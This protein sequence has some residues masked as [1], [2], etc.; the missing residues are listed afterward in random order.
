MEVARML[1]VRKLALGLLLAMAL[2]CATVSAQPQVAQ[3]Q[4]VRQ[5]FWFNDY[6]KA[7]TPNAYQLQSESAQL[8]HQYVEAKKEDDKREIRKHMAEV[9]NH[10]FDLYIHQEQKE[11][12]DLDNQI[13][14]LKEVLRKRLDAKSTIVE[15]RLE[16]MIQDAEGL[17]WNAPTGPHQVWQTVPLITGPSPAT[18]KK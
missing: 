17:G 13:A 18:Q 12:E 16:Q 11:L 15:R 9:L 6:S 8:A 2:T 7:N 3:N 1:I 4:P 10:E 14:R 5:G